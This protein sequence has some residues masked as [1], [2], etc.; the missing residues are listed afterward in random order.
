M[1]QQRSKACPII[2]PLLISTPAG[3]IH[4]ISGVSSPVYLHREYFTTTILKSQHKK[5]R[6]YNV[7]SG[8]NTHHKG[9]EGI[10]RLNLCVVLKEDR[11]YELRDVDG[12]PVDKIEARRICLERYHVPDEVRQRNNY[13]VR[14]A[15]KEEKI[16]KR[17]RS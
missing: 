11:P 1:F 5:H 9:L 13:R 3:Y 15:R 14:R 2:A 16:E 10:H 12:R 17:N 6:C 4:R 8:Q 7:S